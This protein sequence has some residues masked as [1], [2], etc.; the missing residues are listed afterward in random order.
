LHCVIKVSGIWE[1]EVKIEA[2]RQ[3]KRE[4]KRERK[5]VG[6]TIVGRIREKLRET[7]RV[8]EREREC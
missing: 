3:R 8:G 6:V 7:D 2:G 1:G 4:E 5:C